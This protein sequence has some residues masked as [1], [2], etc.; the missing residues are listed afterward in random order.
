MLKLKRF[1]C[2]NDLVSGGALHLE[3]DRAHYLRNVLRIKAGEKI[4]CFNEKEGE[5]RAK[6]ADIS[7]K[8]VTI[9]IEDKISSVSTP[10]VDI[11]LGQVISRGERMDFVIQKATELGATTITPLFSERCNV[12]LTPDRAQS[13]TQHWTQ[14]AINAC[15]QCGRITVPKVNLPMNL[16]EWLIERNEELLFI[17]DP[18]IDNEYQEIT[19]TKNVAVLIGPEGGFSEHEVEKVRK[20]NFKNLNLGPR[21]LRTETATVVALTILQLKWGDI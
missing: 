5:F 6:V 16:D 3:G 10:L 7:K 11:H 8:S 19:S 13:R 4:Q 2:E 20:N 12:K 21:I 1:Y 18:D 17:C 14:I 9:Q 15:E